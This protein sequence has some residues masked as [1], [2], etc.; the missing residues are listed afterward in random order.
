MAAAPASRCDVAC[1]GAPDDDARA[2]FPD[3]AHADQRAFNDGGSHA[4]ARSDTHRRSLGD[5]AESLAFLPNAEAALRL[6]SLDS[7]PHVRIVSEESP[8]RSLDEVAAELEETIIARGANGAG[9]N[10]PALLAIVGL[11]PDAG[12]DIERLATVLRR[13]PEHRIYTVGVVEEVR[14]TQAIDAFGASV[15]FGGS[16]AEP[17][18]SGVAGSGP[19]P[20]Q[21]ALSVGRDVSV[22]LTPVEVRGETLGTPPPRRDPVEADEDPRSDIQGPTESPHGGEGLADPVEQTVEPEIGEEPALD[23]A[24]GAAEPDTPVEAA[25]PDD[26]P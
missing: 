16:V 25:S 19:R 7:L 23:P 18:V 14:D 9:G 13:G 12:P 17:D 6:G 10:R 5:A 4:D 2:S 11:S 26:A 1:R 15:V 20:G 21:L 3:G 8:S 22:T 24:P